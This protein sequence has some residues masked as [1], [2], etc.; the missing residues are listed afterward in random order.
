MGICVLSQVQPRHDPPYRAVK[1]DFHKGGGKSK[2]VG[3]GETEK[4]EAAD[5]KWK[6]TVESANGYIAWH[7]L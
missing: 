6:H 4:G 2:C 3:G 1:R 5:W 7:S